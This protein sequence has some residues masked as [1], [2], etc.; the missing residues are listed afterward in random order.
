LIVYNIHDIHDEDVKLVFI[1]HNYIKE[2]CHDFRVI[3]RLY[4]KSGNTWLSICDVVASRREVT[5]T[6]P[7]TARK[8]WCRTSQGTVDRN[9]QSTEKL[10]G[11]KW[12]TYDFVYKIDF[13]VDKSGFCTTTRGPGATS[14][15]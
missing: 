12:D 1:L 8:W 6:I 11:T 3:N 9:N 14:L 10:Q 5:A 15:T 4:I 13:C 7:V 2:C